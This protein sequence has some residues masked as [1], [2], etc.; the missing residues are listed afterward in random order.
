MLNK[1]IYLTGSFALFV[2]FAC[3]G[4]TVDPNAIA[5]YSENV[6]STE[7]DVSS[8]T[9]SGASSSS[10]KSTSSELPHQNVDVG[11]S[12]SERSSSDNKDITT[13]IDAK[14]SVDSLEVTFDTV[15]FKSDVSKTYKIISDIGNG[16]VKN[17]S[18]G[19]INVYGAEKGATATCARDNQSYS[20]SFKIGQNNLV[21]RIIG[22]KN[23]GKTA[24]DSVFEI[25][26]NSCK[27]A[28][29]IA[30]PTGACDEAG[31]LNSSCVYKDENA[32]FETLVSEFTS[33]SEKICDGKCVSIDSIGP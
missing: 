30:V 15:A 29:E 18:S 5:G 20:A 21:G 19:V 23:Y 26:K 33:D 27:S 1:I 16:L 8:S 13:P 17:G 25:F 22:L 4:G 2:L 6:S 12:S 9:E 31:N 28:T 24:C 10:K 7:S 11:S 32:D 14:P 3:S